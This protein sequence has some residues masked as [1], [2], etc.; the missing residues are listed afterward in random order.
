M[1]SL[2]KS[3]RRRRPFSRVKCKI[4][5][6]FLLVGAWYSLTGGLFLFLTS[7]IVAVE[8]EC[9]HAF[10]AAKRGYRLNK[11][12]LMPYG[13]VIDGDLQGISFKDEAYIALCGPLCNLI[14]AGFFVALWWCFPDAYAYT[15]IACYSSLAIALCNLLPAYPLDGGRILKCALIHLFLRKNTPMTAEKRAKRVCVFV[16]FAFSVFFICMF[17]GACQKGVVNYTSLA[18]GAFLFFGA[19]GNF[20]DEAGYE[21]IDFSCKKA[22]ERGVEVRRVAVLEDKPVKEV[23]KYIQ[24]GSYLVLEA[25]DRRENKLF[26]ITQNQLAQAFLSSSTPYTPLKLL[27]MS[28]NNEKISKNNLKSTKNV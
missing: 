2:H 1:V 21:K 3:G 18:F 11:I 22:L 13:A 19:L 9:A 14:T 23:L 20:N 16:T 17:V 27:K 4:H 8:H 5:P 24:S 15:D 12:V 7:C 6:L 10:A 25:Y 26:E 28:K